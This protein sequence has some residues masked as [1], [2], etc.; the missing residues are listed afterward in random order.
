MKV[1]LCLFEL[2]E[3]D[4]ILGMDFLTKYHAILDCSH[5]EVV[6]RDLGK[7]EIKFQGDKKVNFGRI[8]SILKARK[9][10]KKGHVAYLAQVV[11]TLAPKDNPSKV[12][13]VCKYI[14]E[15]LEELSG[16]LPKREIEFT[17]EV[18]PETTPISQSPYRMAPSKLKE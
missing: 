12:P 11:D 3:L 6:L 8:I 9:L 17:M 13:I 5:K 18:V 2:D 7:F 15:F 16:F 10:M 1:D 14:D 4:V